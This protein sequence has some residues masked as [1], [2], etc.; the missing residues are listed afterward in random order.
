MI[1]L[2]N[3]FRFGFAAAMLAFAGATFAQDDL[4]RLTELSPD[5]GDACFGRVYDARHMAAHPNQKVTRIFFFYGRDPVSRPNEESQNGVADAGY[6]G[7]MTTTLRGAGKPDWAG[8]WCRKDSENGAIYC[9]MECDRSMATL[10][11]DAKGRLVMDGVDRDIYLD[12]GAEEELGPAEFEKQALGTDDSGFVLDRLPADQCR[13]EFASIDPID[14]ALGEPLRQRLKPDQPFCFGR[15]YAEAHLSSH[16]DQLTQTIRVSRGPAEIASIDGGSAEN[17]PSGAGIMVSVTTHSRSDK[18]VQNYSC[19]GEGDQWRCV[20]TAKERAASCDLSEKE[21]YLRRGVNG[22]MMLAN[23]NSSMPIG[24]MCAT[25][26]K[27]KSD[28]KVFR[29]DQMPLSACGL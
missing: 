23:P 8:G 28:D 10:K 6:N 20:A 14:P 1:S 13:K 21:I 25:S 16:P 3:S 5:G 2:R 7:F 26:G 4:A 27:T 22:T 19:D 17:W 18:A 29:L 11:L 9:G 12:G 15:D 24:D